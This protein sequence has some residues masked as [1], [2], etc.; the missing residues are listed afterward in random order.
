VRGHLPALGHL[1]HSAHAVRGLRASL[2][3]A[4]ALENRPFSSIDD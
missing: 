2:L 1:T 3:I 4:V